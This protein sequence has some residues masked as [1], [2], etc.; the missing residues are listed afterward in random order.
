[1]LGNKL[2]SLVDDGADV[3][4]RQDDTNGLS[5]SGQLPDL[6]QIKASC[7]G[8]VRKVHEGGDREVGHLF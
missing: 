6:L 2:G 4:G 1:M 8:P 7:K 3:W 5:L